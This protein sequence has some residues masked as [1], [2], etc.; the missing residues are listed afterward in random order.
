MDKKTFSSGFLSFFSFVLIPLFAFGLGWT[1]SEN[2]WNQERVDSPILLKE[3]ISPEKESAKDTN[4]DISLLRDA[5]KIVEKKFINPDDIDSQKIQYGITRGF[6]W[7]L[8]DPYSEF[9][10]PEESEDFDHDLD[11]DL[12]GIGAELTVRRGMIIVVSPLRG[13]PAEAAGLLPEDIILKVDGEEA[14]GEDFL[15]V[16]KRVRGE[17]GTEVIL[18]VFRPNAGEEKEIT[19]TRDKVRVETVELLWQDDIAVLEVSQF[20]THTE[21]EFYKSLTLAL[22]KDPRGIILDLRFN[23]GGFL[24]TAVAMLSAF[25]EGQ[26]KVVVQKGRPPAVENLVTSGNI[27]TILPLVVLQN[28]GSASASEIVA[29]A[30]QDL[31]RATVIGEQSFG[32]GT[33]QELIPMKGGAHLRLTIAKWLTPNGRDI[34]KVGI[35]P[36]LLIKRTVEDI[37]KEKDPQMEAALRLLH[38]ESLEDLQSEFQESEGLQAYLEEKEGSL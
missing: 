14:R 25:L 3:D 10:S 17:K 34:G 9:M 38:G 18:S 33:V 19:I 6:I 2:E 5:V 12:E 37:E 15:N 28:K 23:G 27:R 31:N 22:Q 32:K 13:S 16:I 24:D 29:G 26:Q 21:Q 8:D 35:E 7:S 1:A 30:L 4:I 11:G 36:D 20:G